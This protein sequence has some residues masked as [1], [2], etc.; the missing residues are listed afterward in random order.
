MPETDG[1]PGPL[2]SPATLAPWWQCH[3]AEAPTVSRAHGL[4]QGCWWG[5]AG[6]STLSAHPEG[7]GG[8]GGWSVFQFQTEERDLS[9]WHESVGRSLECRSDSASICKP[10]C[11]AFE[12]LPRSLGGCPE[13]LQF[14][15]AIGGKRGLGET[16]SPACACYTPSCSSW[17]LSGRFQH[18]LRSV[19]QGLHLSQVW[20]PKNL[21]AAFTPVRG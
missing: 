5:G 19:R 1:N 2:S 12:A 11:G 4:V 8:P 13:V 14:R 18:V 21:H 6:D 15:G 7:P 10:V 3:S 9:L 17:S 20:S 16:Q